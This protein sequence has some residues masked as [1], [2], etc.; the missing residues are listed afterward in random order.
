MLTTHPTKIYLRYPESGEREWDPQQACACDMSSE[1]AWALQLPNMAHVPSQM[2]W[3]FWHGLYHVYPL[4]LDHSWALKH[5]C[6]TN[7]CIVGLFLSKTYQ[8]LTIGQK[9]GLKPEPSQ[10]EPEPSLRAWLEVWVGLSPRKPSPSPGIWAQ[11]GPA[12]H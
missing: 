4:L 3:R 8:V 10:A 5:W 12:H 11:P 2:W 1:V 6:N 9:P 7:T